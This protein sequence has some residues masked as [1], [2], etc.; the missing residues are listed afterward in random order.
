MTP[1]REREVHL[2]SGDSDTIVRP[3]HGDVTG[4]R[5]SSAKVSSRDTS[6]VRRRVRPGQAAFQPPAGSRPRRVVESSV[7]SRAGAGVDSS[8]SGCLI[9][10][11]GQHAERGIKA[12]ELVV[13]PAPR[14][15]P[16]H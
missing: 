16:E 6:A 8:L 10:Q 13:G 3:D 2:S 4:C 5:Q 14:A 11:A 9:H 1:T 7:L 12:D 15:Y